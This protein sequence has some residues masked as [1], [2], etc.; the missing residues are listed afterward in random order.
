M[1]GAGGVVGQAAVQCAGRRARGGS[2]L[3]PAHRRLRRGPRRL[4]RTRSSHS[5]PGMSPS[6]PGGSPT[7]P[8]GPWTWC[9]IRSSAPRR[10][11]RPGR[12]VPAGGSSTSG[13]RRTRRAPS[14]P[15]P[16]AGS[17]CGCSATRTTNSRPS[18]GRRRSGSSR[19][20]PRPGSWP[21]P[22]RPCRW[23][24][25]R[26]RGG[27]RARGGGGADRPHPAVTCGTVSSRA[28]SALISP[29]VCSSIGRYSSRSCSTGV[30][31]ACV[32]TLMPAM[33]LPEPSR[34]GAATER[35][36][37]ELLVGQ[38]PAARPDLAQLRVPLRLA[39]LD[40]GLQAG[41]GRLGED[42]VDLGGVERGELH[43]AERGLQ[44]R[45]PRPDLHG[46]RDDLRD[47]DARRRRCRTRRAARPSTTRSSGRRA[48]PCAGAPRPTAPSTG[49]RRPRG[50]GRAAS[51]RSRRPRRARSRVPAA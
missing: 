33:T 36:P 12:C 3:T 31:A 24:T 28:K 37:R 35:M 27:V 41:A 8:T 9:S 7:P 25:R 48:A 23:R 17:R 46:Q 21:S 6:W 13:V 19:N 42:P 43:L 15:R 2:S 22:T 11:Q 18:S 29:A 32:L 40:A 50:R 14:T 1:L 44:R 47:G 39:E 45:E 26:K 20:R 4:G 51:G 16:F 10:R 34:S 30:S 38:R 49:R 5:T